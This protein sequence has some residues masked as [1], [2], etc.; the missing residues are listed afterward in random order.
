LTEETAAEIHNCLT[1]VIS[2]STFSQDN[3]ALA[4]LLIAELGSKFFGTVLGEDIEIALKTAR[5]LQDRI[6]EIAQTKTSVR[7]DELSLTYM[8]ALNKF[9]DCYEHNPLPEKLKASLLTQ[10]V[11]FLS[12]PEALDK[13]NGELLYILFLYIARLDSGR[14]SAPLLLHS[15][16]LKEHGDIKIRK[17]AL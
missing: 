7:E 4:L 1:Q 10:I 11:Q 2:L 5:D 17:E 9:R 13:E 14:L 8:E 6:K 3:Q 16:N 12:S 15:V